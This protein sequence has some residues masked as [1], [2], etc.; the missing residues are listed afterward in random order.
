MTVTSQATEARLVLNGLLA[1]E[2]APEGYSILSDKLD[3]SLGNNGTRIGT[4]T[5]RE[6]PQS[7]QELVMNIELLVQFYGK[8]KELIDPNMRVDPAA[9][10][11]Y[12]ERFK[13]AIQTTP[14]PQNDRVWYYKLLELRYPDDPTGNKTRFEALLLAYGNNTSLV[15]TV[16]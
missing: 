4:S 15:E 11:N 10:E 16:G 13:R 7:G 3:E 8:W 5:N 2:Y 6:L 14:G 12:A 9:I 1:T